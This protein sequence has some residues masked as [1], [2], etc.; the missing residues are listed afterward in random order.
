MSAHTLRARSD[1]RK[2]RSWL[3]VAILLGLVAGGLIAAAAGAY[4]TATVYDRFRAA[5]DAAD[6]LVVVGCGAK[7]T[8]PSGEPNPKASCGT[9]RAADGIAAL[10]SVRGISEFGL[11]AVPVENAAG[12]LLN[13]RGDSCASGPGE[14]VVVTS[15][16]HSPTTAINR[17]QL[18]EGQLPDPPDPKSVVVSSSFA[19]RVGLGVG[20]RFRAYLQAGDCLDNATWGAPATLRIDGIGLMQGEVVP[21]QGDYFEGIHLSASASLTADEATDS[22]AVALSDGRSLDDLTLEASRDDLFVE[23]VQTGNELAKDVTSRYRVDVTTLNVVAGIGFL[24]MVLVLGGAIARQAASMA[25]DARLLT[26]LGWGPRDLLAVGLIE[27]AAVG[28]VAGGVALTT[29][30][31]LS[32]LTPMGDARLIEPDKG[33]R[34]EPGY[35]LLGAFVVITISL[36]AFAIG[37]RQSIRDQLTPLV[38]HSRRSTLDRFVESMPGLP[39]S[40]S[41]GWR[42]TAQRSRSTVGMPLRSGF[43]GAAL[44]LIGVMGSLTVISGF[45]HLLGTPRLIG[46][47]WDQITFVE[48]TG[49]AEPER[50]EST[51][52]LEQLL[53][54][55]TS[56]PRAR[57]RCSPA[58]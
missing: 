9:R 4:R 22:I 15:S 46:W 12:D 5:T 18:S 31:A 21:E 11:T 28:I 30:V 36:A 45:D 47:N 29:A 10:S 44:G 49:R 35:L 7:P 39:V 19:D 57:F 20:D 24:G 8:L 33:L 38:R 43:A 3:G 2:N 6:A 42:M 58:A 54:I 41:T 53:Q 55:P 34:I 37:T 16:G 52:L 14:L 25:H 26:A 32:P 1:L 51:P 17:V 56:R 27:G 23:A 40:A 13:P 50:P 48:P